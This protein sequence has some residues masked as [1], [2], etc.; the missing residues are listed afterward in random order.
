MKETRLKKYEPNT[1]TNTAHLWTNVLE[2]YEEYCEMGM[3]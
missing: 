3:T 2:M 1:D